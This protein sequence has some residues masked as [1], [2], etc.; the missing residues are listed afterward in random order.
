MRKVS[1]FHLV[2]K[3][4]LL[5]FSIL[6]WYWVAFVVL[7][8]TKVVSCDLDFICKWYV[9]PVFNR[10]V[11]PF[12]FWFYHILLNNDVSLHNL[13]VLVVTIPTSPRLSK[14]EF[15]CGRYCIS[16]IGRFLDR[17]RKE[18]KEKRGKYLPSMAGGMAGGMAGLPLLLGRPPSPGQAGHPCAASR[19]LA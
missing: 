16:S 11:L 17:K 9:F 4:L 1:L 14:T 13:V 6:T 7:F 10:K 18:K 19:K 2:A 3:S 8:P 5:G 12:I 15:V